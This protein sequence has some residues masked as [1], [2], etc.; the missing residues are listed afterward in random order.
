MVVIAKTSNKLIRI[1]EFHIDYVGHAQHQAAK[2]RLN[3]YHEL[4]KALF[5][6]PKAVPATSIDDVIKLQDAGFHKLAEAQRR[7][8]CVFETGLLSN[9]PLPHLQ[10]TRQ[11]TRVSSLRVSANVYSS[12][13]SHRRRSQ[14]FP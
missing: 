4:D 14:R 8:R 9:S 11:V 1:R 12:P 5:E 7:E 10:A 6:N 3:R 2:D 13:S